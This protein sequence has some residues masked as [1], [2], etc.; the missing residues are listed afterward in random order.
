MST[1]TQRNA[2]LRFAR[3]SS[4][5]FKDHTYGAALERPMPR[6]M[7]ASPALFWGAVFSLAV[8]GLLAYAMWGG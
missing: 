3:T 4:E 2:P 5:A 8:W 7:L 1:R 6:S